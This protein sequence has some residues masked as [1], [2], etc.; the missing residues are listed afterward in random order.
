MNPDDKLALLQQR[1]KQMGNVIVAFSGGVDSSFLLQA[2]KLSL[3]DGVLAVTAVSETYP[4]Q[5]LLFAEK[6]AVSLEVPWLT[7]ETGELAD[8]NFVNNPPERC[9]YCKNEL[10][11]KLKKLALEKGYSHVLDGANADDTN[12]FR[13]GL[14]A[15]KEL[16]IISPLKEAGLTK[17]EIRHLS[18]QWGLPTWDKPSLAC[19]SSRFPY[20]HQITIE[21]LHQVDQGENFLRTLGFRQI[22]VRHHGDIARIELEVEDMAKLTKPGRR[23]EIVSHF[24]E[25]GFAYITLDLAGFRSGSMN[26]VLPG[27]ITQGADYGTK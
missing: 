14:K 12:D 1:L 26:E 16:G 17:G 4:H 2:A 19:L 3:G 23:E 22:R 21:K 15:G 27:S 7:L 24:K 13:P 18:R 11:S 25:L 10:F 5:E 8:P 9:Y 6:L 20:G